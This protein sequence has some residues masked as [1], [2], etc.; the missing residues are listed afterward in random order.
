LEIAMKRRI[1]TEIEVPFAQ[2]VTVTKDTLRVELI[3]GRTIPVPLAWF[4]RLLDASA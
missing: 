3:D 2:D 4:P 1:S